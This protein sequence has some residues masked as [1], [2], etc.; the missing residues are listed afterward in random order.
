MR[1]LPALILCL[2]L[3][4]PPALAGTVGEAGRY[5]TTAEFLDSS[6]PEGAPGPSTLW[7]KGDL[8]QSIESILGHPFGALRLRYWQD[9]STSAWV[10]E[11]VGKELPITIGVSVD[12]GEIRNVRILEFRESRGWEVRY[13]FFT[14]QFLNARLRADGRLDRDIDS[15]SGATLSVGAVTR[16]ARIALILHDKINQ[17]G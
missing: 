12:A 9:G 4:L 13:P 15:I 5:M 10:L 14:E 17:K 7:V 8:R 1:L 2:C 16:I 6:F 3:A 11:E